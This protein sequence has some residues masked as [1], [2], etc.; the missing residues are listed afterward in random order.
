MES[1]ATLEERM[2]ALESCETM[3]ASETGTLI[4]R[5]DGRAFHTYTAGLPRP[6]DTRVHACMIAATKAL[7]ND[8]RPQVAYTQSDEIVLA[9]TRSVPFGGRYQKIASVGASIAGAAFSRASLPTIPEKSERLPVFDGRAF[10]VPSR[11]T[12]LDYFIWRES[13][14]VRNSFEAAC[15]SIRSHKA[16]HGK[17][18]A[19][20]RD[21]LLSEGIDWNQ[22]PTHF[23]RGIYFQ[24]VTESRTLT[25]EERARIPE[26]HRP[27]ATETF[28]RSNVRVIDVPP[29]SRNADEWLDRL[30]PEEKS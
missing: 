23:K 12:A 20:M 25:E 24:R 18:L 5:Y 29:L 19:W 21:E 14:A 7:I 16:M 22:Y 26:S 10:I 30:L 6:F 17:P 4:A 15:R 1:I 13:D 2:V 8:L 3:R 9:W 11:R 28:Q 27:A